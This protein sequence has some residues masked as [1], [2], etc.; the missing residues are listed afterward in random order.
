ME[1]KD[2]LAALAQEY[3]GSKRNAL[4]KWC[5]KKTEGYP[6]GTTETALTNKAGPIHF[7]T[8]VFPPLSVSHSRCSHELHKHSRSA[9]YF[10][11]GQRQR[12]K[13]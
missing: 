13:Y 12:E 11:L 4:L 6:V 3:G 9:T 5:Q 7:N 2:P 10:S 1:R 8:L